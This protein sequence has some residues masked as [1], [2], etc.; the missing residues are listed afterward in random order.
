MLSK[1]LAACCGLLAFALA[2][3]QG[4]RVDNP[5]T[6]IITRAIIGMFIFTALGSML[7]WIANVILD[8]YI[9]P[10][11]QDFITELDGGS[12]D[13]SSTVIFSDDTEAGNFAPPDQAD[14]ARRQAASSA[15]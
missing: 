7:G 2:I 8:E 11:S 15:N 6:T 3:V 12:Q 14:S 13:D 9:R 4:V 5:A 1:K 10:R